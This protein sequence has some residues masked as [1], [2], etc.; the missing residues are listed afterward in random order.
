MLIIRIIR[1]LNKV[2]LAGSNRLTKK[3]SASF[4]RSTNWIRWIAVLTLALF[5]ARAQTPQAGVP[6]AEAQ[7]QA[8]APAN[9]SP[10]A[11]EVIR[12]ATSGVGD[13]VVLAYIQN[14]Q[15]PFN[16]SAD[17]VLYLKDI[18]LSPQVTSAML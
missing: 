16:L 18:G 10:S 3:V 17:H 11:A 12:L 14:S 13:E 9:L 15:A 1:R 8:G 6:S 2:P 7:A 4:M 5:S